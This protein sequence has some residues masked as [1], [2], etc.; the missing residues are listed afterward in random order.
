MSKM[1]RIQ[2]DKACAALASAWDFI[3]EDGFV[4]AVGNELDGT[5]CVQT[6]WE[7]FRERFPSEL[8]SFSE[9]RVEQ[10]KYPNEQMQAANSIP[11]P[12]DQATPEDKEAE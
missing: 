4:Y 6:Q 3:R 11:D 9:R 7:D 5:V 10:V 1:N 12:I 8:I 2:F